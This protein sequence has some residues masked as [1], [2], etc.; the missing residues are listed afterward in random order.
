MAQEK[1]DGTKLVAAE[2]IG[3]NV[4]YIVVNDKTYIVQP[5]TIHRLSGAAFW[6]SDIGE[7]AT[8]ADIF[9]T[10]EKGENL[11]RALSWFIQDNDELYQELMQGSIQEVIDALCQIYNTIDIS[12]FIKLSNLVKSVRNLVAKRK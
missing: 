4:I 1:I 3:L 5:P 11:C 8:L 12:N 10:M 7:G 6:L 9:S 2:I